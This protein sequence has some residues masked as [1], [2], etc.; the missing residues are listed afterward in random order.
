MLTLLYRHLL[1]LPFPNQVLLTMLRDVALLARPGS[2]LADAL[3]TTVAP[4]LAPLMATPLPGK[5]ARGMAAATGAGPSA[6]AG[7]SQ[8][9]PLLVLVGP[10]AQLPPAAQQLGLDLVSQLGS[11][12]PQLLKAVALTVQLSAYSDAA[13]ARLLGALLAGAPQRLPPEAFLQLVATLLAGPGRDWVAAG[14]AGAGQAQGQQQAEAAAAAAG[15]GAT[16]ANGS[17]S[18][19]RSSSSSSSSSSLWAGWGRHVLVVDQVTQQLHRYGALPL[20]VEALV[21][22]LVT[23][24]T[25]VPTAAPA[26]ACSCYSLVR[27]AAL[28]LEGQAAAPEAEAAAGAGG[29]EAAAGGQQ[30]PCGHHGV[31]W[32]VLPQVLAQYY[33]QCCGVAWWRC[34]SSGG[35]ASAPTPPANDVI[36]S[37]SSGWGS[38]MEGPEAAA[39]RVASILAQQRDMSPAVLQQV[40]QWLVPGGAGGLLADE[41]LQRA[42]QYVLLVQQLLAAKGL[43]QQGVEEVQG[44]LQGLAEAAEPL[45]HQSSAAA[46]LLAAAQQCM[47]ACRMYSGP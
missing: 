15:E 40:L 18:S 6:A 22:C 16:K 3:H 14:G 9:D 42:Q 45:R 12:P 34:G 17:S 41:A 37:S 43:Q 25:A 10:L 20:L 32:A 1:P 2:P 38:T 13:V 21:P 35:V 5:P 31:L 30:E 19:S 47:A 23:P 24:V 28:L 39:R 7:G 29:A 44:V 26:A 46:A 4:Q 11:L 8:L 36:S 33:V 27:L